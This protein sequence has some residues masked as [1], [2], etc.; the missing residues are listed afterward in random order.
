MP[1][2]KKSDAEIV[3][4]VK[5]EAKGEKGNKIAVKDPVKKPSQNPVAKRASAKASS[6]VKTTTTSSKTTDEIK[7]TVKVQYGANEYDL[8]I[9]KKTVESEC[10]SKFNGKI[11]SIDIY[12]KPEDSAVYYVINSEYSGKVDL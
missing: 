10:Y 3:S 2:K 12:I 6:S 11:K 7:E 9:I 5:V 8:A 1:R 4:D